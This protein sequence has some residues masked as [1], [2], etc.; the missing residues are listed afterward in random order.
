M[1][2]KVRTTL[3][4]FNQVILGARASLPD[5]LQIKQGVG[6]SFK[7]YF[8]R[9]KYCF[10]L[11]RMIFASQRHELYIDTSK[12]FLTLFDS[13]AASHITKYDKSKR[14]LSSQASR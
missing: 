2:P 10:L 8:P 3:K 13:S 11:Q 4:T 7:Q 9:L 14:A 5:D 12:L 1:S 6:F